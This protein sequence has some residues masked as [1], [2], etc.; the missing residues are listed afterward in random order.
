MDERFWTK[1]Y[2]TE[3]CWLWTAGKT[4]GYGVFWTGEKHEYAHRVSWEDANGPVPVGK[5]LAHGCLVRI[6]VR[7]DENHVRPRTHAEN[8][9]EGNNYNR[10]KEAC[11]KGHNY[12]TITRRICEP[13]GKESR[14]R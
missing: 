6:C 5:E 9:A 10:S 7:P 14:E 13:C 1:V 2:K 11:P 8:V 4:G 12:T 3:D